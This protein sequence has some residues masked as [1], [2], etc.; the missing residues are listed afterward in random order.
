MNKIKA[1]YPTLEKTKEEIL[2]DCKN[3]CNLNR[4]KFF[5]QLCSKRISKKEFEFNYYSEE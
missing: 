1:M 5:S 4:R 3:Y 2:F